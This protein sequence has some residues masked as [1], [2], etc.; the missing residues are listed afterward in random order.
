MA[1]MICFHENS[2]TVLNEPLKHK[3]MLTSVPELKS[4]TFCPIAWIVHHLW[5]SHK[6]QA[7]ALINILAKCTGLKILKMTCVTD[8][9]NT[10]NEWDTF[11]I[12]RG[13]LLGG[14]C[15]LPLAAKAHAAKKAAC[16]GGRQLYGFAPL[17]FFPLGFV[18]SSVLQIVCYRVLLLAD[19]NIGKKL[20]RHYATVTVRL[21]FREAMLYQIGCFFTHCVNGP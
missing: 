11:H 1:Y 4:E 8:G 19:T 7:L 3:H 17:N 20:N 5:C 21:N 2:P 18:H 9:C 12:L 16:V 13:P 10:R 15:F 6:A 14:A